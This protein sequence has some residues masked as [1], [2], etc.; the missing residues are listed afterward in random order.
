MAGILC[1]HCTA[2]CCRY[3]ALPIDTPEDEADF[4]DIRWFLIH[5]R[6]SVFVE[7]GDWYISLESPCRHLQ[8]DHRCGIYETRPKICRSYSADDCDY[9]SGDYGWEQHFT[10][11]AHLDAYIRAH[12]PRLNTDTRRARQ[13]ARLI[14]M[15]RRAR[16]QC[17]ADAQPA[18][19]D[20]NHVAL[21]ILPFSD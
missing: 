2:A 5:E 4:D 6:V 12:P 20:R 16:Q 17:A 1:E 9:H 21:P 13:R 7:D 3:I 18:Q 8:P 14:A 11:A 19:R 15:P 10:C